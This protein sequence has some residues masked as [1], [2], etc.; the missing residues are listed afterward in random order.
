MR[1]LPQPAVNERM[2]ELEMLVAFGIGA[3]LMALAP[4]VSAVTGGSKLSRSMAETGRDL[5]KRGLKVGVVVAD[6]VS[7]VTHSMVHN[8]SEIGESFNDLVAEARA[9]LVQE[10]AAASKNGT[11]VKTVTEVT[12]E[13]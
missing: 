5:T 11:A 12:V 8:V 3:G 13:G 10:R 2:F 1:Y 4:A 6:K 7:E 9:D